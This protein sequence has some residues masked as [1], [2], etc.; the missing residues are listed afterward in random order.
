MNIF[1]RG[2]NRADIHYIYI[3]RSACPALPLSSAAIRK[4]NIPCVY[5]KYSK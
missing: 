1:K 4:C 5:Y 3:K 2:K